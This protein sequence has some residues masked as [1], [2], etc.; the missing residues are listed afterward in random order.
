MLPNLSTDSQEN[1][2]FEAKKRHPKFNF[3]TLVIG[4]LNYGDEIT[5]T[6]WFYAGAEFDVVG[7]FWAT[8]D[9]ELPSATGETLPLGTEALLEISEFAVR[10]VPIDENGLS[11]GNISPVFTYLVT[12][13]ETCKPLSSL[14]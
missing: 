12:A 7:Y 13:N 2:T 1:A 8:E 3:R 10:R 6:F 9:G 14:Y 5:I 11:S 4:E